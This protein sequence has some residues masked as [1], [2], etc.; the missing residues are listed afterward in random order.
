MAN[1][2][3]I[4][5]DQQVSQLIALGREHGGSVTAVVVGDAPIAGVD[6]I[7]R[8]PLDAQTPAEVAVPAVVAQITP[9]AGDLILAANKPAERVLAGGVA[10]ALKIPVLYGL[11]DV[12]AGT[13]TLSRFGG[14][15]TE[16]VS[17]SGPVLAVVDGGIESEGEAP[18]EETADGLFLD[19]TVSGTDQAEV[20]SVNLAAAKRVVSAGRGFKTEDDLALAKNLAAALG[21][22]LACSRPLAEGTEWMPRDRYVG[23]SGVHVAPELYVAVGISGQI[24]HTAGM[25][26]SHTVIAINNDPSAP[27]MAQADYAVVGDLY[28][29]LPQLTEALK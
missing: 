22:E 29:V 5:V 4:A 6:R 28:D 11:K 25:V 1:T 13:A 27:M 9:E 7:V 20:S 10:A 8:I 24:Q 2:W 3:I 12:T 26:E 14:I 15:L 17:F 23:I 18:S 19:A 21:A 16:E